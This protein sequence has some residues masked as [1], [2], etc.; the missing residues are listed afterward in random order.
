[1]VLCQMALKLNALIIYYLIKTPNKKYNLQHIFIVMTL[2]EI[3][4]E[5][6]ESCIPYL[7]QKFYTK[8]IGRPR[9]VCQ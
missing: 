4:N 1:M 5:R 9:T 2:E 6:V 3:Q 7:P 8:G